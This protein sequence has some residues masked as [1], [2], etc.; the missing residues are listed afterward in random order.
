MADA[1]APWEMNWGAKTSAGA[2]EA[3]IS[4]PSAGVMPWEHDWSGNDNAAAPTQA[5]QQGGLLRN[6]AAGALEGWEGLKSAL[7][8][9]EHGANVIND[10][11]ALGGAKQP[12]INKASLP[13]SNEQI[14]A[15]LGRLGFNPENVPANTFPE[16]VARGVGAGVSVP[17]PGAGLAETAA[18]VGL[19]AISGV[20]STAAAELAPEPWKPL[21]RVIGGLAAPSL[22]AGGRAVV[23]S[24]IDAAKQAVQPIMAATSERAAEQAAA[25]VLAKNTTDINAVRASL[26]Q[27]ANEIVKGS[28]PTTFQQ[29]GDL[30]LGGLERAVASKNP[31]AFAQVRADQNAAR[32]SSLQSLRDTGNPTDLSDF[33][34]NEMQT[35]SNQT[36]E[37]LNYLATNAY[38]K[39][40]ALGGQGTPEAYGADLRGAVAAAEAGARARESKLW[41]AVDP[42]KNMT[43]Y[44]QPTVDAAKDI[45]GSVGNMQ[46]PMAG[47]EAAIFDAAQSLPK[48]APVSDLIDLRSR[49]ST[50]MRHELVT[51]GRSPTYARLAQLRGAIQDNLSDSI[52]NQA[53]NEEKMVNS[54][55]LSPEDTILARVQGWANDWTA[56]KAGANLAQ[57]DRERTVGNATGN[58]GANG[59]GLPGQGGFGSIAGDQGLPPNAPAFDA[60]AK[61]RLDL[62]TQATKERARTFGV[63]PVQSV[64]AKAGDRDLYRLPEGS[65]PAKF[66]Q[67]GPAGFSSV[68]S[69][70]KAVGQDKAN[71]ILEDYAAMSL[72]RAATNPDGTLSP[73]RFQAWRKNYANALRAMPTSVSDNFADAATSAEAVTQASA[74]R[75]AEIAD[76][77]RGAIAK[78]MNAQT[79]EDVTDNVAAIFGSKNSVATMTD[80]AKRAA[81]DP[82]ATAGLKRS[83]ADYISD[84][85]ISNTEAGTS[86]QNLIRSDQFQRFITQNHEAL[87]KVFNP[88][89]MGQLHAIADDLN[90]ANRSVTAVKLPGGS[91]TT[92]DTLANAKLPTGGQTLLRVLIDA[93]GAAGGGMFGPVGAA[94]GA[95]G[96]EAIQAIRAHGIENINGLIRDAM[97]HPAVAKA[98]LEKVPTSGTKAPLIT[99]QRALAQ[100][101][102]SAPLA[103]IASHH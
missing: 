88:D 40:Q 98:L 56:Q 11:A 16:R 46:R 30:G 38:Q 4:G 60:A 7:N 99:L 39:Y 47:E 92:Q 77:N 15:G 33:L 17:L 45:A 18:N 21:A 103:E 5:P 2:S 97:V 24:G 51:N 57:G 95:A 59:T 89:E 28:E 9:L 82:S 20:G 19:G 85:F 102:V 48:I 76:W 67:S 84:R 94:I 63:Q 29:T 14:N 13:G 35:L 79:P 53:A 70:Y 96:A 31:E 64:L 52:A 26:A 61:A 10:I 3:A 36:S 93:A 55:A 1:P 86:G 34:K 101:A 44:V 100:S 22:A 75:E 62:A 25:Q 37:Q 81:I 49:V 66:F 68:Q 8:P 87:S 74:A 65:V 71:A 72:K 73:M 42:N 27:G 90:R 54:G 91:N 32:V 12:V 83:V 50:E 43:G 41:N 6:F 80:L 69:L 23:A 78:V 58:A